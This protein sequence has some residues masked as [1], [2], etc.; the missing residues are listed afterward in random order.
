M[1]FYLTLTDGGN[2]MVKIIEKI[3]YKEDHTYEKVSKKN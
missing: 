2:L 3:I 1:Y